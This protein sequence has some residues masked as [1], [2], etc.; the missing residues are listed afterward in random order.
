MSKMSELH[1]DITQYLA[2]G[3]T[4]EEVA[5]MLHVPLSW[6]VVV[7]EDHCEI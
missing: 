6:V 7:Y 3:F 1:H 4:P 5:K 2:D